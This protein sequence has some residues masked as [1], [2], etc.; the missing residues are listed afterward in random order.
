MGWRMQ[1]TEH[2]TLHHWYSGHGWGPDAAYD[3]TKFWDRLKDEPESRKLHW[4]MKKMGY[5]QL[6]DF[7]NIT[8]NPHCKIPG[9]LRK[10]GVNVLNHEREQPL[11]NKILV[12]SYYLLLHYLSYKTFWFLFDFFFWPL[13]LPFSY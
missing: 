12:T 11:A 5:K 3:F 1:T 7:L 2:R 6:C 9:T 8:D 10:S 4:N 13:C